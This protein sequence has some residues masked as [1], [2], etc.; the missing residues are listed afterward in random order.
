MVLFRTASLLIAALFA[1]AP[2]TNATAQGTRALIVVT[3]RAS[4]NG[5]DTSAGSVLQEIVH[6]FDAFTKAGWQVDIASPRGGE[7]PVAPASIDTTDLRI[8]Q[9]LRDDTLLHRL[10]QHTISSADLSPDAY[11]V[12]YFAGG[13]GALWDFLEDQSLGRAAGRIFGRRGILA[14]VG[15][16]ATVLLN[17]TRGDGTPVYAGARLTC[18]TDEELEAQ[19][20]LRLMPFLLESSLRNGGAAHFKAPPF[21]ANTVVEH[22]LITGQNSASALGVAEAVVAKRRQLLSEK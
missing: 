11:D 7:A 5:T 1:I 21:T 14:T 19:G 18:A 3:S 9:F 4:I 16:G 22:R 20:V 10:L 17:T 6:P 2:W 8:R 12:I 13:H 15:E